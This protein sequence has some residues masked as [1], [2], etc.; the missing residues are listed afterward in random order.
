MTSNKKFGT[1]AVLEYRKKPQ[2]GFADIVEEFD[3]SFQMADTGQRSLTWDCDDVA[4]LDRESLRIAL[5]WIEPFD[6]GASWHLVIAVGSSPAGDERPPVPGYFEAMSQ[7]IVD[8]TD[9]YLPYD[10][11]M[12]GEASCPIGS[13]LIDRVADLLESSTGQ[14]ADSAPYVAP[15][16]FILTSEDEPMIDIS[17]VSTD[18]EISLPKRLTIYTLSCSFLLQVPAVGAFMLVY[19]LL[20]DVSGT[21]GLPA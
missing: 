14:I 3:I 6:P 13:E 7:H 2:L 18:K 9:S 10:T 16:D 17:L 8:H 11:V 21:S 5:G 15:Q 19:S 1:I 20:R 4:I 12:Q